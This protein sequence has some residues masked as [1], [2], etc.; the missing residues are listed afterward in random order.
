M[1]TPY[2]VLRA[3]IIGPM[4]QRGSKS[5]KWQE[6]GPGSENQPLQPQVG[7]HVSSCILAVEVP[8]GILIFIIDKLDQD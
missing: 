6:A 2:T 4:R 7:E 3:G 8:H 1:Q 5:D